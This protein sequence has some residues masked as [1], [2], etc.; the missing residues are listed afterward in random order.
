MHILD[1]NCDSRIDF[2]R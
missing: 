2:H 1:L